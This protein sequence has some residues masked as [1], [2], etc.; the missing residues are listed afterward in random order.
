MDNRWVIELIGYLGSALVVVSMLM[1]SVIKLRVVNTVGSAIF[2]CYALIIGSYP[3]ALMNLFLIGINVYHLFRLLKDQKHYDLIEADLT[4]GYV[5]YFLEKNREDILNWF[6]EFTLQG[7]QADVV[8]IVCCDIHPAGLFIGK[9][10][11]ADEIEI[12]LDY[13]TPSYRDTSAGRFLHGKLAEKGC[14]TL[15]FR[16]NAPGHIAYMEKTGYQ[17]NSQGDYVLNLNQ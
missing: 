6:P 14:R 9:H 15:V 17:R 1:T 16:G 10:I 13:T 12:L 11:Q 2:M 5:S 4:D 7:L 3:T 8:M